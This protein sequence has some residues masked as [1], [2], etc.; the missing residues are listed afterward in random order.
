MTSVRSSRPVPEQRP[1]RH[2]AE[3][4]LILGVHIY[5]VGVI[6][7]ELLSQMCA[8]TL[9][10]PMPTNWHVLAAVLS[11]QQ[12]IS[13]DLAGA[14]KRA[15]RATVEWLA[16]ANGAAIA[17]A[18]TS[19]RSSSC[20]FS[21]VA[22]VGVIFLFGLMPF[23][24]LATLVCAL[25]LR[26]ADCRARHKGSHACVH[27]LLGRISRLALRFSSRSTSRQRLPGSACN[28]HQ[29]ACRP[30]GSAA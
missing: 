22:V 18:G 20:L 17:V 5:P 26:T 19:T 16:F 21:P 28:G 24:P 13:L 14:C 9:F 10:D 27:P 11:R 29:A 2:P 12:A 4:L 8:K 3:G 7:F 30:I 1:H 15:R 23:A 6:V 25:K